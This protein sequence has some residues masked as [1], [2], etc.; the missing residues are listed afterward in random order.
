MNVRASIRP[1][2]IIEPVRKALASVDPM[3]PFREVHTM[4]EEVE[5]SM[6]GERLTAVLA[7]SVGLC[8]ALFAGV[9]IYG[10]LAYIATER[11]REIA[12]RL[13][14]GAGRLRTAV[15]MVKRTLAMVLAGLVV[16]LAGALAAASALQSLL[17]EISPR[18]TRAIAG[19]LIFVAIVASAA[20]A[21]PLVRATRAAPAEGLR[22]E[23]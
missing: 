20:T 15:V 9:G 4:S 19:T 11:R 14:L 17:F 3:M 13:A 18:D 2:A 22:L 23:Q 5:N 12:I 6:A 21:V 7:S 8:A 1:D 16:G 10:S